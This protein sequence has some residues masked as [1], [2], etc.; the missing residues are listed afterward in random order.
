MARDQLQPGING[1]VARVVV[2]GERFRAP[3]LE[4][5]V[6]AHENHRPARHVMSRAAYLIDAVDQESL[7]IARDTIRNTTVYEGDLST[8]DSQLLE[9]AAYPRKNVSWR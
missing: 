8:E 3:F 4:Q 6:R 5:D 1:Q 7:L 2:F 9:L